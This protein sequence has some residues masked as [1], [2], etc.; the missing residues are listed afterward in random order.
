VSSFALAAAASAETY[1]ASNATQFAEAVSKANANPGANTIVLSGGSYVPLSTV[2]F[3]NTTGLQTVEGPASAPGAKIQGTGVE[4]FPSEL[5]V[6]KQGVSVTFDNLS[7][8]FGGGLGVPAILDAGSLNVEKSVISGNSGAGIVVGSSGT[9]V[10]R[11]STLSDGSDFG[12]VDDGSAS[13]FNST[14]AFNKNGGVENAGTLSLT[15]TIVAENK[16]SGDCAG[17]ANSSD[18]SLDSNGSCGVGALSGLNPLLQ[19]ALLNNGG[20]TAIHSLKPGS[21][22]IDAGDELLCPPTDQRGF[23]RPDIPGTPCD[24]GADE[25][26]AIAPTIKVPANITAPATSPSGAVVTYTASAEATNAVVRSFVCT[27]ASGSKFAPGTTTVTCT[28]I[29][30]H[31]NTSTAT[32]QV[33]V[34]PIGPTGATGATGPTGPTGAAGANGTNG[35]VGATGATGPTGAPGANGTNGEAG[36]NGTNGTNGANGT[37]GMTGSTG[38]TGPT[39]SSG[40]FVTG[41][42]AN[43]EVGKSGGFIGI[44]EL[45]VSSTE[46]GVAAT[47][48][49]SNTLDQLFLF[50]QSSVSGTFTVTVNGKATA[51]KCSLSKSR[52][53]QDTTD[54]APIAAGNTFAIQAN[55]VSGSSVVHF[56]A[57]VQ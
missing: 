16:G 53:C 14:V 24:I 43:E 50:A 8:S 7:I 48:P 49:V 51:L 11:N 39:G 22:A 35:E 33:T 41:G 30:G 10:V 40:G 6:V 34:L 32:F 47:W 25:Y 9:A 37:N 44:G 3:T 46:S 13:F 20:P 56:R 12:M 42:S 17:K 21:P 15:N 29:D 4:P 19:P 23:P 28:A 52:S 1:S 54:S 5:F 36:A 31:E 26:S 38:A 57:R 2:A 55:M 18:H 27:P 45:G